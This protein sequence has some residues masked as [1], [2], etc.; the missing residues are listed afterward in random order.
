MESE[1]GGALEEFVKRPSFAESSAVLKGIFARNK[2]VRLSRYIE[3]GCR[4]R[5]S[6]KSS[7]T[8]LNNSIKALR[9]HVKFVRGCL[10]VLK[11]ILDGF[12]EVFID[13]IPDETKKLNSSL[14]DGDDSKML[15]KVK[16][17]T[18]MALVYSMLEQDYEMQ[19]RIVDDLSL[20]TRSGALESYCTL[21]ALRPFVDGEVL[22]AFWR[23]FGH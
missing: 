7:I 23:S 21:W 19:A 13:G 11:K 20:E 15:D 14:Q 5:S 8:K 6:D 18:T 9:D 3:A 12:T 10:E 22:R 17:I 1:Q 2:S 4:H 16:T